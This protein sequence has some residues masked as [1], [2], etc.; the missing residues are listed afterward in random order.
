MFAVAFDVLDDLTY[1]ADPMY[2]QLGRTVLIYFRKSPT[3]E[4]K[5]H[6]WY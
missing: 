4:F 2:V 5:G 3:F 6:L 1:T